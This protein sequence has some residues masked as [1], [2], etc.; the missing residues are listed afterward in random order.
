MAAIFLNTVTLRDPPM[1]QDLRKQFS[2]FIVADFENCAVE[3]K[4]KSPLIIRRVRL[5]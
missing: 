4:I 5:A 3:F 2:R 1:F